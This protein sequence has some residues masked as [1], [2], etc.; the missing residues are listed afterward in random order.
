[1]D[2]RVP[3][4]MTFASW[5]SEPFLMTAPFDPS[6]LPAVHPLVQVE[7]D[8]AAPIRRA[9]HRSLYTRFGKRALDILLVLAAAPAIAL[10][11]AILALLIA[12][13][14]GS[15]FFSQMRVGKDGR[16]YRMWKLRTMVVDADARLEAHLAT[17]PAALSEWTRTQKLRNDPRITRFGRFLRK[18]SLDELPQLW[19]VLSGDM[20]LVGPRPML[21]SQQP[22]YPGS[23]YYNLRPGITG[24]WQV[25]TRNNSEF[26]ER[27]AF[28]QEYE[29]RLSFGTDLRLIVA[30][31]A[32]V[33]RGTGH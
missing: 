9:R 6:H 8:L 17:D 32:V 7:G 19:N 24:M 4:Q 31:L 22:L 33:L 20:S 30:T 1:M 3:V 2:G 14:G 5:A 12:R 26:V 11:V 28:D 25:S 18:S 15:P 13:D 10:T 21:P 23:A 16:T 29:R 27:A